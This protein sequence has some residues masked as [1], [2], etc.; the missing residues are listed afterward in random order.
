[1]KKTIRY[2]IT[3]AI[4]LSTYGMQAQQLP[5]MNHYQ[6]NPYL[7]NPARTG[8]KDF[9]SVALH[10]KKQWTSMPNSPFTGALSVESPIKT[11]KLGNMGLGGMLYVDQMHVLTKIGGLASYAY[12][13]PFEK[14]KGYKHG[15]SA[16]LS[17]GFIHQR[18][19]FPDAK[20]ENPNDM[21]LLP[22]E[23]NGT[24]FD[25]SGGLDY[26][27]R[28]LHVGVA[29]LQGLNSSL[30]LFNVGQQDVKY[31]NTRHWLFSASY[32]HLFGPQEKKHRIYIEP[33]FLGRYIH[34]VPFIPEGNVV[35]GVD[36]IAWLGVGARFSNY[37]TAT[38]VNITAGVEIKKQ[39]IFAYS[40]ELAV[41][42]PLINNMGTQ[43]EFMLAYRFGDNPRLKKVEMELDSTKIQNQILR[44]KLKETNTQIE[45][46]NESVENNTK[47][48]EKNTETINK[49]KDNIDKNS[50]KIDDNQ[51]KIDDNKKEIDELRKLIEDQPLKYKKV[52]EVFF[53]NGSTKLSNESNAN[54]DAVYNAL[55]QAEGQNKEIKVYV[56]GNAS[57]NGN[58][59]RNMELSMRRAT[60]VRQY[61]VSKGMD[62]EKVMIIPMGE[63]D[64]VDGADADP[65]GD[66]KD[67]RVDIIFTEKKKKGRL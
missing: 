50:S 47:T 57:T 41:N 64:P 62:G 42:G 33:A 43:H 7:Y 20:V 4:L 15:L 49:N 54:L 40:V 12:H 24:S 31:V 2:I 59:K 16:G 67:R 17:L 37:V 65:K 32:K 51:S 56:K 14:G 36:G 8:Q 61:L 48:I 10:F 39:F 21:A 28:G 66:S 55:K 1:M 3:A 13:I 53:D 60:A 27:W 44:E 26:Q 9:G 5:V 25:F 23:T 18:I 6:Y 46:V 19:N 22:A 11:K 58:A 52:G 45:K 30:Q 35:V 29:M 63:S 38:S 34:N